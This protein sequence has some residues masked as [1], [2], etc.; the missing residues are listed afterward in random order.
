MNLRKK[1]PNINLID[2]PAFSFIQ[3]CR[4]FLYDVAELF[5]KFLI[6]IF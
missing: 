1:K 6:D 4:P 5:E 3:F 2:F